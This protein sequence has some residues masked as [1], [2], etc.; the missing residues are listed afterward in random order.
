MELFCFVLV[1]WLVAM[2]AAFT[3]LFLRKIGIIERMQ[4]HGNWF[5]S[6]MSRCDFCL[7]FWGNL[8]LSIILVLVTNEMK[9]IFIPFFSTPLSR[10]VL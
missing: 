2:F 1:S 7:S 3:L 6:Q 5:F 8:I 9:Y 4:V 10:L